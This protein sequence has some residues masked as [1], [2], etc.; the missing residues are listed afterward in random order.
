MQAQS[1]IGTNVDNLSDA[2]VLTIFERGKAQGLTIENGQEIA[3]SNGL[4]ASEALKFE[5]RLQGLINPEI[6]EVGNQTIEP[7]DDSKEVEPQETKILRKI[8]TPNIFGHDYFNVDLGSFDKSNG[9]KAPSNYVLGS[10]D[11][12]TIS[13]FGSSYFQQTFR[14]SE[15]G[16]LNLGSKFGRIK[17]RGMPFKNVEKLL[18]SRFA[19][20]FDLSKNTFDLSL[21]YGRN[22]SI[23]IVGEVNNP[24]TYSMSALNNAFPR[25]GGCRW[26]N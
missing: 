12:L 9:A 23:N 19:R 7:S 6:I 22:I 4:S 14:V 1:L 21:S 10:D 11:E 26:A 2:Q 3:I 13:I 25:S 16:I 18:R 5:T 15:S 20:G 24:G 8:V 17:V